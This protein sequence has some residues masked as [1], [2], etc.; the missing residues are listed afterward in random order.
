VLLL[1]R[2]VWTPFAAAAVFAA[3]AGTTIA[4]LL[5]YVFGSIDQNVWGVA[6]GLT[7]GLL[8]AGL[9]MLAAP[10]SWAMPLPICVS[11]CATIGLPPVAINRAGPSGA[12][13]M[14]P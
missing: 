11:I 5:R 9:S 3:I 14:P 6:A 1:R 8:A 10:A 2:E 4:V 13:A 7:L 12:K